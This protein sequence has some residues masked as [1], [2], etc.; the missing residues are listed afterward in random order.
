MEEGGTEAP[1][2]GTGV[3]SPVSTK[4][5]RGKDPRKGTAQVKDE[6][7]FPYKPKESHLG[8]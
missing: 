2:S 1:D 8:L 5:E 3:C 6:L 4:S 7:S